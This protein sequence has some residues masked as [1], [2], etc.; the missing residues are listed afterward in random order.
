MVPSRIGTSL[1][2]RKCEMWTKKLQF[3]HF[4]FNFLLNL[5]SKNGV[6]FVFVDRSWKIIVFFRWPNLAK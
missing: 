2:G 6:R 4:F 1:E 5:K 3:E